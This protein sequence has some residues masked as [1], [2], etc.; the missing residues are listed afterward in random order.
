MPIVVIST[1][2]EAGQTNLGP[3]SLVF[4]YYVGGKDYHAMLLESRNSSNTAKNIIRTKKCALNFIP[5]KKKFLKQCVAL[6]FPGDTTEEKMKG[7]IFN[8][9]D[10]LM[11][12][13]D[14]DGTY[15]LVV[16]DAF[17][18]FE[19]TWMAELDGAEND[20]VQEKYLPP[21][22]DFNGIT[23]EAGAH[24]ILKIDKIL[25]KKKFKDAIINGVKANLFPQV[26]VDYGYRDN[27]SFWISQFKKPYSEGI[28]KDKG[29]NIDS[30]LYA[31]H[32]IDPDI[33][34][35]RD[36]CERLVKVPRIFLNTVL[37]ACV[38][39]AREKGMT[40]IDGEKMDM[41]RDKRGNEK[42]K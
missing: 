5:A 17:Q 12:V 1:V 15:P 28:A 24:F 37:N 20:K 38:K 33:S 3:Y 19:C 11:Q 42:K 26:P 35:T 27:T 39:W 22:H 4:P 36:A 8:L 7:C 41:I 16:S 10:G 30:V 23:S 13:N 21:Y 9:E 29:T 40:E 32:R 34:F 6:G 18:V 25:M 14:P 31:A 2:N